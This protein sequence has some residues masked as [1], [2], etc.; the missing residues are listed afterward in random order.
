MAKNSLG[1]LVDYFR[2]ADGES[3]GMETQSLLEISDAVAFYI[4]RRLEN[5]ESNGV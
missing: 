1:V 3:A 4:A 2:R 5:A